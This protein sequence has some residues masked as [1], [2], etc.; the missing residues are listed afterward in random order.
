MY[1][2]PHDDQAPRARYAYPTSATARR[3]RRLARRAG[4]V[5]LLHPPP[6]SVR[7]GLGRRLDRDPYAAC[8][9]PAL[10]HCG[11]VMLPRLRILASPPTL[12]AQLRYGRGV[13]APATEP[14][15]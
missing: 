10:R 7:P 13:R 9:V 1:R 3:C 6:A 5:E 15:S 12:T 8:P 2:R 4:G 14:P 11:D